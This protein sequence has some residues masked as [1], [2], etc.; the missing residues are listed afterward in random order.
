MPLDPTPH[1]FE[2]AAL[3]LA[4]LAPSPFNK[5]AINRA[6]PALATLAASLATQQVQAITVR[7]LTEST[8]Q[9]VGDYES[10]ARY[11]IVAGHRRVAAAEIAGLATLDAVIR[12]MTDDEV[13]LAHL[14]ENLQR[15][16]LAAL[17]E[18]GAYA[19]L[20]DR[21]GASCAQIAAAV[22][23]SKSHVA[24][25]LKLLE[26]CPEVRAALEAGE[27]GAEVAGY[28]ARLPLA[29]FQIQALARARD[30]GVADGGRISTRRVHE[31][32]IEHF[33]TKLADAIFDT[34][35]AALLP[36]AG[37]CTTCVKR[38]GG[39][40]D[41]FADIVTPTGERWYGPK[42]EDICTDTGCFA[43]KKKAH[44]AA[45]AA[46]L[47]AQ[48]KAVVAGNAARSALSAT[49][50]VKGGY[51]ALKDVKDALAKAKAKDKVTV[52]EIQDQRTG[53]LIKAVKREDAKAAGVKLESTERAGPQRSWEETHRKQQEEDARKQAAAHQESLFRRHL[54][55]TLRA[56]YAPAERSATDLQ[57]VV[58]SAI[59]SM[60]HAARSGLLWLYGWKD[61]PAA[62]KLIPSLTRDQLAL[63]LL[64][65]ALVPDVVVNPWRPDP[66]TRL[67]TAANAYGVD[68]KALRAQWQAEQA[69]KVT[70]IH[71]GDR[72]KLKDGST[73]EVLR[74][75][76]DD[77]GG[78][79]V[80]IWAG[81]AERTVPLAE[82]AEILPK[83]SKPTKKA[84]PPA[85]SAKG[86]AAKKGKKVAPAAQGDE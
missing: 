74:K 3:P 78:G 71:S 82:V 62:R 12:P 4:Q 40:P 44:L 18:A 26:A 31:D 67:A 61:I 81:K 46:K 25:R 57:L 11:Q 20:R 72:V 70:E 79:A 56:Q 33:S 32:L 19:E 69:P 51:V 34:Q 30:R 75:Q 83:A 53:K 65:I 59:D 48:G 63:L 8:T 10:G 45:A 29:K 23:K 54:L 2:R 6:D 21:D 14:T 5:R 38:S 52:V 43:E 49:G 35:D 80:V 17:E 9:R 50:E 41:L 22:G 77:S 58:E 73:H 60:E 7:P 64:D 13:R 27:I 37:A 66:A 15:E 28:I 39:D 42:G 84:A 86:K 47:A 76:V 85:K 68:V 16:G 1:T 36:D 55:T 24:I